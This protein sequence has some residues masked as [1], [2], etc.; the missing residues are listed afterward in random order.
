MIAAMMVATVAAKAQFEP[1]T[2]TLQPKVGI[3]LSTISADDSKYKFGIGAGIEGQYQ[4]KTW[5]GL[6]AAVMYNQQ[7]AKVKDRDAKLNLE[8][9][10]I[11]IMA[12]FYP[13]K[14]LSLSVGVQPG[15]L[16][17]AKAKASG[18]AYIDDGNGIRTQNADV[19]SN[20]NKVDFSIPLSIGYEF[21]NGLSLEARYTGGLTNVAKDADNK[22]NFS[23]LKNKNEV[24]MLT[25][26]YKFEL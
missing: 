14:G 10:N 11:P 7:G 26:G 13:T 22:G 2:F 20:C 21:E 25:V 4:L 16:T 24:F 1:G 6:S 18:N 23:Y 17:K 19:K 5:F 8:Y 9:I 15:F 3:N 12:K